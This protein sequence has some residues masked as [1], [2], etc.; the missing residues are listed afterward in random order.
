MAQNPNEYKGMSKES[1]ITLFELEKATHAKTLSMLNASKALIASLGLA[2][3]CPSCGKWYN[4]E[5]ETV[6]KRTGVRLGVH[7]CVCVGCGAPFRM[8]VTSELRFTM[9]KL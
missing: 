9:E 1:L 4:M 3:Y 2:P 7:R 8:E 6:G 5:V